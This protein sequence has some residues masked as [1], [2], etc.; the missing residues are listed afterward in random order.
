MIKNTQRKKIIRTVVFLL[1]VGLFILLSPLYV[2]GKEEKTEE[3]FTGIVTNNVNLNLDNVKY[4]PDTKYMEATFALETA[5]GD[6]PDLTEIVNIIYGVKVASKS[7]N[8]EYN[9]K[10]VRV[11]DQFFIVS[12]PDVPDE[13]NFMRF[14]IQPKTVDSLTPVDYQLTKYYMSQSHVKQDRK[15]ALRS[16]EGYTPDFVDFKNKQVNKQI[17]EQQTIIDDSEAQKKL[18]KETIE[19]MTDELTYQIEEEQEKTKSSIEDLEK[20]NENLDL[21]IET[22]EKQTEELKVKKEKIQE[23]YLGENMQN[24]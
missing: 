8:Q 22:A 21:M 6:T 19:K 7:N 18:N 1:F 9:P 5:E 3:N 16:K 24:D 17:K 23:K 4:N 15:L 11:N 13:F 20:E 10:I 12:I 2:K 14:E